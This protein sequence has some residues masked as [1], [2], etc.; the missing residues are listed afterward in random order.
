MDIG[1][2]KLGLPFLE[3]REGVAEGDGRLAGRPYLGYIECM[4]VQ[5]MPAL[6]P[7]AEELEE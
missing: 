4:D 3:G 1:A 2:L 6:W 7:C 5:W